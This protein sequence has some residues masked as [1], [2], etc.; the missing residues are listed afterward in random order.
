MSHF[1]YPICYAGIR[2]LEATK[3][4]AQPAAPFLLPKKGDEYP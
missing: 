2:S 3:G 4:A 1:P